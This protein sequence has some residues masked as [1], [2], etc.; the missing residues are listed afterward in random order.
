M[1]NGTAKEAGIINSATDE[2]RKLPWVTEMKRQMIGGS[3][4][5]E[6]LFYLLKKKN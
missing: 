3:N 2:K 4:L 5:T 1:I 6:A